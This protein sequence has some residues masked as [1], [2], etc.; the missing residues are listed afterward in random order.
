ML[1]RG[2]QPP[3]VIE[4]GP[5]GTDYSTTHTTFGPTRLWSALLYKTLE[6]FPSVCQCIQPPTPRWIWQLWNELTRKPA[7]LHKAQSLRTR[8]SPTRPKRFMYLFTHT[9]PPRR[10]W[11]LSQPG[12]GKGEGVGRATAVFAGKLR[13]GQWRRQ[14]SP[15]IDLKGRGPRKGDLRRRGPRWP[16][17]ERRRELRCRN[18]DPPT[19]ATETKTSGGR[20]PGPKVASTE[21]WDAEAWG[22]RYWG[23]GTPAPFCDRRKGSVQAPWEART[24]PAR[25]RHI[26][27]PL[28]LKPDPS[29]HQPCRAHLCSSWQQ[30]KL[31]PKILA[32]APHVGRRRVSGE[33]PPSPF[34]TQLSP[35]PRQHWLAP[36]PSFTPVG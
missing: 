35:A 33:N 34:Y 15:Q 14:P 9:R 26:P 1:S 31:H 29:P 17:Q 21:N 24:S 22:A 4:Q 23:D 2:P 7:V 36:D 27:I 20:E 18:Q 10:G 5:Q 28:H 8:G 13:G 30:R 3:H 11:R 19:Q 16:G 12:A 32:A 25:L 6:E